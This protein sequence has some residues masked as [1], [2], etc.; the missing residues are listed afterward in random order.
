MNTAISA[1]LADV[2]TLCERLKASV[3]AERP[4]AMAT[5]LQEHV[6]RLSGSNSQR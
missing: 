3:E 4:D 1:R 6:E 5:A 2:I